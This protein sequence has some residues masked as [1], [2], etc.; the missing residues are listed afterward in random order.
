MTILNPILTDAQFRAEIE[1]CEFCEDRPCQVACPADCSP[2]EFLMAARQGEP[3]DFRRSAALI[4]TANPLGGVCGLLCP[5]THCM[6][7][8]ARRKIDRPVEIPSLQATIVARAKA[9]G[10]IPKLATPP[11]GTFG[12]IA[13]VGAGPAGI[14]AATLLARKGFQ[15]TVLEREARA[16]GACRLVPDHR[17]P[18]DVLDTDLA[19]ALG[20]GTIDLRCNTP[21]ADPAA[22]LADGFDGVVV[23]AGL[24]EPVALGVPGQDAAV[25]G[26]RYLADPANVDVSGKRVAVL[27]AGATAVD[28]AVTAKL[29]G[30]K[31]VELIARRAWAD[32]RLTDHE[33]HELLEHGIGVT[34]S[35][36]VTAVR[37]E[38]GTVVGLDVVRT[39]PADGKLFDRADAFDVAGSAAVRPDVDLVIE[40]LGSRR[41]LPRVE[42]ARIRYG[43]DYDHG[44]TTVVTAVASG[45]NAAA[46]LAAALAGV[47][48]TA[49]PDPRKSVLVVPGYSA[50]PV[51]LDT[52]FFG[53]T[54]RSPFLLSA[55]P[56]T[57]GYDQMTLAF[58]AGWAGGIM[59]TAFDGVPIH[60]PGEY[61]H[62]F[63]AH[64]YGNCDNVSGH[65]LDRVCREVERLVRE[66]PDRLVAASTGGPVTG[67][68]DFDRA[69]WQSN[70]RK[71]DAAGAMAV[72]YSLSCPQGGD[73]TEGD[74]VSQNA[75]LASKIVGWILEAS[76]P[77]VPKLF[78]LTGAVTS[79]AV[80]VRALR[81]TMARYPDKKAGVTLANSFP[82]LMFRRREKK[83][84]EEGV[85]VGM[86]GAGVAPISFLT[87]AN[88]AHLGVF[89]SGNGGPMDYKA[90][91]HF[92][93]LGAR[94]VQFCTVAMKHGV[95]IIED[96]ES[97]LS[98][99]LAERGIASVGEL[100][101]RALPHPV[102]A[103]PD[104]SPVKKISQVVPDL[105][106]GCG[107]CGRCPYLAITKDADGLPVTDPSL[108]IG[109]S[110]CVQ[111]CFA[112]AL[113]MR[114]R[115]A[116]EPA[117]PV[118]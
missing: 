90:A 17:L 57:D 95:G 107:N 73:G 55:A 117:E 2:A 47:A 28:C 43:G 60:I 62:A 109:C 105:C 98:H 113:Y 116:D 18:K 3:S 20:L 54:L 58:K 78:K 74:I 16:G 9:L 8:C 35:T 41:S 37:Q 25:A 82:S 67:N 19:W 106:A 85:V 68:D 6:A 38:G 118:H 114:D 32:F 101:G 76:A 96:L 103:F 44:A 77:E 59:K 72:E 115:R 91:A 99:L 45:K 61:M 21:V 65:S 24:T 70:T 12:K 69:G 84:W 81:A 111:K 34:G 51:P 66:W 40:A 64:T 86:S 48:A 97:G 102:T 23:T 112:G 46:A 7:G 63:D 49:V 92:L 11:T 42:H 56:P 33:R 104:L 39:R 52:D 89:V 27:G 88:V 10:V 13:V 53:R 26:L 31:Q 94:N 80:I 100:I 30:A 1:R 75:A 14:A 4:L 5:D 79:I 50:R 93:A 108:C 87:L 22:L 29:R 71:L 36:R 83:A 110:I 15:V